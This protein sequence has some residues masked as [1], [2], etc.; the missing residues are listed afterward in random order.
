MRS[1]EIQAHEEIG[2]DD[3]THSQYNW[4]RYTDALVESISAQA[5]MTPAELRARLRGIAQLQV[6]RALFLAE[7]HAAR[8]QL[9]LAHACN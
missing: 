4:W 3:P 9:P 7:G 6:A 8:A 2:R 5:G 1:L